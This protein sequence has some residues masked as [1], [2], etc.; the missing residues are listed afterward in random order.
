MIIIN[1]AIFCDSTG[2][3]ST[4][5]WNA[6]HICYITME[7]EFNS[8]GTFIF[9]NIVDV[10]LQLIL[11][12]SVREKKGGTRKSDR[13]YKSV[14]K[15]LNFMDFTSIEEKKRKYW[16]LQINGVIPFIAPHSWAYVISVIPPCFLSVEI[17]VLK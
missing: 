14:W 12:Q 11:I 5:I 13:N 3:P 9:E 16:R 10:S 4:F 17:N 15:I 8:S 1:H 7:Q 6:I 2:F